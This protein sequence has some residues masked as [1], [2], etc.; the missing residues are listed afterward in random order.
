MNLTVGG[1]TECGPRALNQDWLEWDVALGLFVLADGMG[2]HNAGEVA[3]HLAVKTIHEFI[4]DSARPG[5]LTWPF[6]YDPAQSVNANRLLTAVRLANRRIFAEG[7][8]DSALEG[9]GTTVVALVVEGDRATLVSVG[10]SRIYRWRAG[11]VMQMTIDDTWLAAVLGHADA[12]RTDSS[13]PLKHVLTSV[14]GTRDDIHPTAREEIVQ[15]ADRFLLCSDGV[16][17]RLDRPAI[18]EIL[19]RAGSAQD[20]ASTVVAEAV[21]RRTT[22]NA[23]AIVIAID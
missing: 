10:D 9:M 15:V 20:L 13:H 7:I 1:R 3:S 12:D 4:E 6:A 16:H 2:G 19:G 17:G 22:D 21:S 18:G 8:R 14:V 23:T 5:D 11:D